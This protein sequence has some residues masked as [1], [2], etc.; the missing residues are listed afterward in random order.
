[1]KDVGELILEL[2]PPI[3]KQ[4]AFPTQIAQLSKDLTLAA[5]RDYRTRLR[6]LSVRGTEPVLHI[7]HSFSATALARLLKTIPQSIQY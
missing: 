5:A 2:F 6:G 1:M 4:R 7:H 3:Q